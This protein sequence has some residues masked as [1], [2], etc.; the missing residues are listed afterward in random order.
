[1]KNYYSILEVPVASSLEEI[2]QSYRRLSQD[3]LDNAALFAQL[4]E[5]HEVLTSPERR[6]DYDRENGGENLDASAPG[7][8]P[9]SV[10]PEAESVSRCPMGAEDHCPVLQGRTTPEDRFCPECGVQLRI[11]GGAMEHEIEG[12][13]P[14]TPV[15][16]RLEEAGGRIHFLQM[17]S[18]IVGR[19][20]A[21]VLMQDK[22]ISRHHARLEVTESGEILLEDLGSTNGTQ[23]NDRPLAPHL[24]RAVANGDHIRFGSVLTTLLLPLSEPALPALHNPADL[25]VPSAASAPLTPHSADQPRLIEVRADAPAGSPAREFLLAP[26]ITSFGRR[27]ESTVVLQG[28]PYVSGS[29]AQLVTENGAVRLVDV[30]ST[31]GTLLNGERLAIDEPVVLSSGDLIVIGGSTLRFKSGSAEET[32]EDFSE[33]TPDKQYLA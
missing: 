30:G 11:P 24:P 12:E 3:N 9:L 7:S 29:H 5:A 6:A 2:R 19:E 4:K 17:G 1:L 22:T 21:E 13:Q 15:P 10:L 28:D 33:Q 26:G 23:I 25:R 31:N 20:A 32:T 16:V 27:P 8:T 18:S 14:V